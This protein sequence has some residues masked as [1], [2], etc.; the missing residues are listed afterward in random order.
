MCVAGGKGSHVSISGDYSRPGGVHGKMHAMLKAPQEKSSLYEEGP[1]IPWKEWEWTL[2]HRFKHDV[3]IPVNPV[4]EE[5]EI[6]S[7][8]YKKW[9]SSLSDVANISTV[10]K[11]HRKPLSNKRTPLYYFRQF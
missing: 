11:I 7:E 9:V 2:Y 8:Q 4:L 10:S 5:L 1:A 6:S 3:R